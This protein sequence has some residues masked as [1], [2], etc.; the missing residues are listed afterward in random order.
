MTDTTSTNSP[1][2]RRQSGTAYVYR[3]P[4][5]SLQGQYFFLDRE[6]RHTDDN[7]WMFNPA[8]PFGT[9]ANIDSLLTPN[10]GSVQFPVSFG[11]DAMGNLYITYIQR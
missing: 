6:R 1:R 5:P 2:H 4:D 3:G 7:Y 8:N 11:E 10:I 9:V